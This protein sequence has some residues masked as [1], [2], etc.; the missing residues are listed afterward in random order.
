MSV[1]Q[2][3]EKSFETYLPEDTI[4]RR[5]KELAAVINKDYAGKRPFLLRS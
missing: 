5:I 3:H 1:V 4:L 2:V